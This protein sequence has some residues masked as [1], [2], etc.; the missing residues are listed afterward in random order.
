MNEKIIDKINVNMNV[1]INDA[2]A[3]KENNMGSS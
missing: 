1:N 3:W 2:D